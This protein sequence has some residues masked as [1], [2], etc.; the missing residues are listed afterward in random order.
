ME[1]QYV[2]DS[3]EWASVEDGYVF[4]CGKTVNDEK[5]VARMTLEQLQ[6]IANQ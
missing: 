3:I 4:L 1:K 2:I 6:N 5:I